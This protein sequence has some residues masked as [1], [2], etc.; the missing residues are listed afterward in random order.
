[1]AVDSFIP[2]LWAGS[3]LATLQKT[4]VFAGLCNRDYEGEITKAGDTV[5]IGSIGSIDIGDYAGSVSFQEV[6]AASTTLVIDQSKY[7]A[8]NVH[9]VDKAQANVD[10]MANAMKEAAYGMNDVI[11]GYIAGLYTEAGSTASAST[12]SVNSANVIDSVAKVAQKLNE[13]SVPS[14]GRWLVI[15]PWFATKLAIAKIY[16]ATDNTETLQN[17]FVGRFLGFD[18]YTSANVQKSSATDYQILGGTGAAI[19]FASQI[20]EVE[21]I[22]RESAFADGVRGLYLY[23][24]KVV[25]PK[26]LCT[27]VAKEVAEA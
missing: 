4:H 9:D 6:D 15:P 19:T 12:V 3:M 22:R 17:G 21:A 7:F 24:A 5:K 2:Q 23:G 14:A 1:M 20:A 27:L 13:Q 8:F 16:K 26:A 25:Q 18:V 10:L 11:D